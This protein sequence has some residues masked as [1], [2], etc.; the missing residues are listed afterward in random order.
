M[1]WSTPGQMRKYAPDVQQDAHDEVLKAQRLMLFVLFF[2]DQSWTSPAHLPQI[3]VRVG[4][5]F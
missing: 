3:V 5:Q 1:M 2:T 4:R